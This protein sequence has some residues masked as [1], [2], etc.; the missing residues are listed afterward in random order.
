MFLVESNDNSL[1]E[2]IKRKSQP[3]FESGYNAVIESRP[4][5]TF[6]EAA[7]TIKPKLLEHGLDEWWAEAMACTFARCYIAGIV[8]AARLVAPD[9]VAEMEALPAGAPIRRA[10]A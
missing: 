6:E 10:G 1:L 7:D 2:I 5:Q 4:L 9:L 3:F 8:A